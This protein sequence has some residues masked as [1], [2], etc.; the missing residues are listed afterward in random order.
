MKYTIILQ[1]WED[2][3]GYTVIVP[4][5]PGC[6]TQGSTKKEALAN[7]REAILCHI[8]GLTKAGETLPAETGE[9]ELARIAI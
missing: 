4:S 9:P 6:I 8:E 3:Q 1:P 2:E 7:A 5:L